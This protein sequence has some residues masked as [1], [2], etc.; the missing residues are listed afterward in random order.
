M[1]LGAFLGHSS[2]LVISTKAQSTFKGTSSGPAY[3]TVTRKILLQ[4]YGM[5]GL[6]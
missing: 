5:L 6:D 4:K 2:Y 1:L 3:L